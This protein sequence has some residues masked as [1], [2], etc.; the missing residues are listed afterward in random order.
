MSIDRINWPKIAVY[1]LSP[2]KCKQ[3]D[4]FSAFIINFFN[5]LVKIA[6]INFIKDSGA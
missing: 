4:C 5:I 2:Q 1:K 3:R 6:F